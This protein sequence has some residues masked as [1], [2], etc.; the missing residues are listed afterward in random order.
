MHVVNVFFNNLNKRLIQNFVCYGNKINS[1]F[2]YYQSDFL[3][4]HNRIEIEGGQSFYLCFH[5]I[6][7]TT[8]RTTQSKRG[9]E[10]KLKF[11]DP[12]DGRVWLEQ[13]SII[14]DISRCRIT[15]IASSKQ[16]IEFFWVSFYVIICWYIYAVNNF[17]LYDVQVYLFA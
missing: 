7:N 14:V 17:H 16:S 15:S 3:N 9:T 5:N 12:S 13:L 8:E 10:K 6:L 1:I 4:N 2:H 11:L